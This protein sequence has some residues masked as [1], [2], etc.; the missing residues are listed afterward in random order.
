MNKLSKTLESI[1]SKEQ[2]EK[3]YKELKSLSKIAKKYNVSDVPIKARFVK[4]K[5]PFISKNQCN[6]CNHNIFS[7]DTERSFY[8][9]GLL[10]ADGCI[11]ISKTNKKSDYLNNRIVIG[12]SIK[13]ESFLVMLRDL[14][15]A[16][17]KFN[18]YTNKLSKYNDKWNDSGCVKL[19]IT[20]K[21]M[22]NDLGRRFNIKPRKS[23][24]YEFPKWLEKHP[25]VN[26]FM[27]GY[28]DG[29]GSF[30]INSELSYDRL[31]C[32][33]RGTEKFLRVYKRILETNCNFNGGSIDTNSSIGQLKFKGEF[34]LKV[35]DFLYQDATIYLDRKFKIAGQI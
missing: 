13:D 2:L 34:S 5:I 18:Y 30:F 9:A 24:V 11:R 8:L 22:V 23:L 6:K 29:D 31:C 15:E 32:S 33:I 4:Y 26:H 19:S 3:D 28:L 7:E 27:R 35:R 1:L 10:A 14:F 21:Q 17:H 20:S 25:L 16:D 12:L